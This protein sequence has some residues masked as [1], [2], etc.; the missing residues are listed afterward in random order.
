DAGGTGDLGSRSGAAEPLGQLLLGTA[1]L[2]SVCREARGEP[3]Q[4]RFRRERREDRTA[5]PPACECRELHV[6]AVVVPL[7]RRDKAQIPLL[8]Q[9]EGVEPPFSGAAAGADDGPT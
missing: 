6:A 1:D 2:R 8:G 4:A 5:D 9:I 3:N 7:D